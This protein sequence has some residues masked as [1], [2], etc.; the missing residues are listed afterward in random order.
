MLG[1]A[2]HIKAHIFRKYLTH[3]TQC[4]IF[5]HRAEAGRARGTPSSPGSLFQGGEKK[6]ARLDSVVNR[7]MQR[8]SDEAAGEEGSSKNIG[9]RGK[10]KIGMNFIR[11]RY[12]YIDIKVDI[13]VGVYKEV[14]YKTQAYR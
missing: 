3:A 2:R 12:V 8:Q 5:R 13:Y 1:A 11:Y 4:P 7:V 10:K 14:H 9:E 6:A